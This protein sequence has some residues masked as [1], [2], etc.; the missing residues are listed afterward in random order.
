[1]K[2]LAMLMA[3]FSRRKSEEADTF[4]LR[5]QSLEKAEQRRRPAKARPDLFRRARLAA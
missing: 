2:I 3:P 1:M 5:L 4:E